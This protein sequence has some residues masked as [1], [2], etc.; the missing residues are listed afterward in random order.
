V[1]IRTI[2][3]EF[4]VDRKVSSLS[5]FARLLFIGLW[6]HADDEGRF[7]SD[8]RILK[9]AL[10]PLD[11]KTTVAD[12]DGGLRELSGSGLV[13]LSEIDSELYGLCPNFKKHQVI[14]KPTP[15]KLP[16]IREDSGS[17]PVALPHGNGSGKGNGNGTIPDDLKDIEKEIGLYL[18]HRQEIKKPVKETGLEALYSKI[19]KMRVEGIDVKSLIEESIS[20]GWQGLFKPKTEGPKKNQRTINGVVIPDDWQKGGFATE[21]D[22]MVFHH[23]NL[24]ELTKGL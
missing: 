14:N 2:K 16:E 22:Y 12:L 21:A 24:K 1:R 17:T 4:W 9:G 7:K 20:N 5:Y 18:K 11:D 19:R 23:P 13:V 15:S 6:N 8:P 3:P 10:F